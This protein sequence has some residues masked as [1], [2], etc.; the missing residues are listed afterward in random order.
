MLKSSVFRH[1]QP[2]AFTSSFLEA[3]PLRTTTIRISGFNTEPASLIHLASD[4]RCRACPQTSLLICWLGF[5]QVG[6]GPTGPHPLGNINQFHPA[7]SEFPRFRIYLGAS[8]RSLGKRLCFF[9]VFYAF[10]VFEVSILCPNESS[11]GSSG[12]QNDTVSQG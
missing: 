8:M 2:S 3:Y 12:C 9:Y 1:M 11:I 6:L 7:F 4:S 10:N 5:G